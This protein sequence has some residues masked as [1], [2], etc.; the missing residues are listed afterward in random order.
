MILRKGKWKKNKECCTTTTDSYKTLVEGF[1][2][3]HTDIGSLGEKKG[4]AFR[5]LGQ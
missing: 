1:Q 5:I 2:I 4:R 3:S